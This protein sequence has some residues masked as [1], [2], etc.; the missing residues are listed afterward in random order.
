MDPQATSLARS[1]SPTPAA[2]WVREE[3]ATVTSLRVNGGET[4]YRLPADVENLRSGFRGKG[5]VKGEVAVHATFV[6]SDL[7]NMLG[8]VQVM[9]N[10]LATLNG[11]NLDVASLSVRIQQLEA[12]KGQLLQQLKLEQERS[13][14]MFEVERD[15]KQIIAAKEA[16]TAELHRQLKLLRDQVATLEDSEKESADRISA[17]E[18]KIDALGLRQLSRGF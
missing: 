17:L 5:D 18:H 1:P 11:R 8:V 6:A 4:L 12:E 3:G 16:E 13:Q 15:L 14:R 7:E 10:P 9:S 2:L